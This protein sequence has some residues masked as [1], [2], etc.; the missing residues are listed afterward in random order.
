MNES[1]ARIGFDRRDDTLY[2]ARVEISGDRPQIKALLR[3]PV[4]QKPEHELLT[5]PTQ[6]LSVPDDLV[7]VKRLR[8]KDDHEIPVKDRAFFEVSASL[9]EDVSQFELDLISGGLKDY[10]I[11]LASRKER[12]GDYSN[13]VA[14][15]LDSF[16]Y[17]MRA[18]A[19]GNGYLKFCLK[20]PGELICLSDCTDDAASV[21]LIYRERIVALFGI[22][23]ER[24][25]W[26]KPEDWPRI[27]LEFRT[28]LN[29][30]LE[31]L[32][33]EGITIPLSAVIVGG[34]F[35]KE[36]ILGDLGENLGANS[37]VL[38]GNEGFFADPAV[39]AG[40]PLEDYIV[41]LGLTVD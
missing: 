11:I 12:L 10:Q 2:A 28:I 9:L 31:I 4:G 16:R 6:Y 18:L 14:P 29:F 33:G 15:G 27:L 17:R 19:L 21:C 24:F 22:K 36:D 38:K 40:V 37:V 41:A 30:Q 20:E 25:D 7:L 26:G 35:T 39:A 32:F 1:F 5:S 3:S 23:L 13:S 34:R 8:L